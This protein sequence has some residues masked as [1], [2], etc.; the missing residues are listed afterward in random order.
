MLTGPGRLF[1]REAAHALWLLRAGPGSRTPPLR[2]CVMRPSEHPE[3]LLARPAFS[4]PP[5]RPTRTF[6]STPPPGLPLPFRLSRAG[7]SS[8]SPWTQWLAWHCTGSPSGLGLQMDLGRGDQRGQ[9]ST[10]Q[11]TASKDNSK[12]FTSDAMS[13]QSRV[14]MLDFCYSFI[15]ERKM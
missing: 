9:R 4:R 7:P 10:R 3:D 5:P 12:T 15:Y 2:S 8:W 6:T 13:H 11:R 1:S 14:K